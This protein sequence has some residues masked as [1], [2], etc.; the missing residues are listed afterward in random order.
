[1]RRL[2]W[3]IYQGIAYLTQFI[4]QDILRLGISLKKHYGRPFY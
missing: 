4:C 3:I 1:M 2:P